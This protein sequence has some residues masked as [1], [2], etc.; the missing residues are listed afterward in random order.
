MSTIE[1]KRLSADS[2]QSAITGALVMLAGAASSAWA[3]GEQALPVVTVVGQSAVQVGVADSANVGKVTQKQL[4]ERTVYRPGELLEAA[5]G[6][7]VSQHSGEGKA[8]QFYL[9]GFNLDHGTDLRT[10]VDGMLVN[11]RSHAHG[12][13]WTDLNFV[14]PE[15]ATGLEYKKGPYYAEEGDFSS[16]GA[17]RLKYADR[18]PQ[19][20][21]SLSVGQG[22]HRRA[23]AADS[24]ALA[25]GHL[26][27]ALEAMHNDGPFVHPDDYRKFNAV[28]RYSR[29]YDSSGGFNLTAM[30]Y[31]GQ[32][33]STDQIP[34]AAIDSGLIRGRFDAMD[35]TDGGKS[36]R[37]SLSG[38]WRRF[39]ED[40]S[41][42][43]NAYVVRSGLRLYS[44]FT[45]FLDDPVRGDQFAQPDDRT[46]TAFN[47]SRQWPMA[48][49][50]HESDNTI[51]LQV[52]NDSIVNAL[53]NTQARAIV[54]QTRADKIRETSAAIHYENRTAWKPWFRTVA[55]VRAD[56]YDVN[57]R[58]DNPLNSGT[59]RQ[60]LASPKLNL[61]FGP[62]SG[63][64]YY[65]NMGRG[66][67]SNDARGMTITVDPKDPQAA[68]SRP[69]KVT[70]LARSKGFELGVRTSPIPGLQTS[71]TLYRLDFASELVFVGDAGTTSA[72]R[73]S[74]RTGFEIANY[75]K[76][77]DWLTIDGDVAF[78]QARFRDDDPIG[79]RIPGA[80]EGVASLAVAVDKLGPYYGQF[81]WRYFGP[82]PL[83]EDNA[84]RSQST[85][86]L[87]GHVGYRFNKN[88]RV[89]L[90]G[91]NLANRKASA[92]DYYYSSRLTPTG[93]AQD[94]VHFHPIEPR[95][96]RLA[97]IAHF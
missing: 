66:F 46:T 40:S 67:H 38:S 61:I 55:G 31:K 18:M 43:A 68:S 29:E 79:R 97:L 70:P 19:G 60:T 35:P 96:F 89:E 50:S 78:A 37:Y 1:S 95:S 58:S 3:G 44:N 56:S 10:T 71:L 74:R 69:S 13:G 34:Q 28:L 2:G 26:L 45:Y 9:R 65:V 32:W 93:D 15:L 72:S 63:T 33:N 6:L 7:I 52:Q 91:F 62:W 77:N 76:L 21:Y 94:A 14:I 27:Y 25:E 42:Y 80:V 49:G 11:S 85:I 64:E 16:A 39:D 88:V 84:V 47:L 54:S 48:I 30:A 81:Q 92:I 53:Q 57:V 4:E 12:Q 20:Q 59:A 22:G 82:R 73:P 23:L 36:H 86:G 87:N 8:N 75:Y 83:T 51:G 24:T 17:V 5:P 41:T 90:Q